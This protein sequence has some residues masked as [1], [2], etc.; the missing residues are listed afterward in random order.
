MHELCGV[1]SGLEY[2]F[3]NMIALKLLKRIFWD[4]QIQ[5]NA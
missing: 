5:N 4:Q 1:Y 3:N 2:V